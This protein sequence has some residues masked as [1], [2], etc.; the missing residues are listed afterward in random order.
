MVGVEECRVRMGESLPEFIQ[1]NV[2]K[3]RRKPENFYAKEGIDSASF[4]SLSDD[5]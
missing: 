4:P 2:G 1:G 3:S 5:D